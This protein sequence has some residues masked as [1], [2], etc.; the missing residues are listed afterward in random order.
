MRRIKSIV[1]A[2]GTTDDN[3]GAA[4]AVCLQTGNNTGGKCAVF[5]GADVDGD[6][7]RRRPWLR[8][9]SGVDD[10]IAKPGNRLDC[11]LSK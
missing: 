3:L 2:I 5:I 4:G 6:T 8:Q 7:I 10:R 1:V 11:G 9:K